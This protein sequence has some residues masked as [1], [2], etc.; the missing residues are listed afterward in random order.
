LRSSADGSN[1]TLDGTTGVE[2]AGMLELPRVELYASVSSTL[3][4][5]HS[6]A[7]DAPSGTLILA[8]EQ[9]SGRGRH[10]RRWTSPPGAGLWITMIERPTDARALDVLAL[11][12][13]LFAAEALD[14]LASGPIGVKWPNDLY[15][16]GRKL[17]G[18]LIETRW[19]G[20]SPE[21]VCI[22]F[23]LNVT[24]PGVEDAIGLVAGTTRLGALARLVPALRRAASASR[25]LSGDELARWRR[26]DVAMDQRVLTPAEGR[27][28]GISSSGELLVER[29]DGTSTRHR[30]GTLTFANPLACS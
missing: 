19:R 9:T 16:G 30:T 5:A 2:L 18:V 27:A 7:A 17:A 11:R 14:A 21:W 28:A 4:V 15:V 24:A 29:D 25:H 20:T 12:C 13:G 3:D 10:G 1:A 26:R 23:G 22:G 6:I 8:D